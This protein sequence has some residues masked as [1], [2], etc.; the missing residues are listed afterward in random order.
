MQTT[1]SVKMLVIALLLLLLLLLLTFVGVPTF[2]VPQYLLIMLSN[3]PTNE[4]ELHNI[5]IYIYMHLFS[6]RI[7]TSTC[8]VVLCSYEVPYI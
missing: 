8:S 1:A 2:H 3:L 5:Y 6:L 7:E 4:A